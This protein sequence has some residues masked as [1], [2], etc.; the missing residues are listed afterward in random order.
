MLALGCLTCVNLSD[1]QNRHCGL[2]QTIT[3]IHLMYAQ[4]RRK[5]PI[6]TTPTPSPPTIT[7]TL[8]RA[9]T[10]THTHTHTLPQH[11]FKIDWLIGF[12]VTSTQYRS[13]RDVPVFTGGGRPQVP[14]RAL[15]RARAGTW[16][17][18]PTF[19]KLAG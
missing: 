10:H 18:P 11:L 13:C 17:E 9:H 14:L 12:Y 15:F 8:A 19:R 4:C 2:K 6:P 5:T 1:I 3:Y 7:H 16:V